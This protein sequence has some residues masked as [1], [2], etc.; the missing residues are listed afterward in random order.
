MRH[1]GLP[2]RAFVDVT[3]DEMAALFLFDTGA[4]ATHLTHPLGGPSVIA[5]AGTVR[6]GCKPLTLDSWPLVDMPKHDGLDLIGV[7][8]ADAVTMELVEL[9]L[10][11]DVLRVH[12]RVPDEVAGWP[13]VAI[14]LVHGVI[15]TRAT[16]DGRSMRMLLD[17]GTDTVVLLTENPGPGQVASTTDAAG[18][19]MKLVWGT[20]QLAWEG[21]DAR[22]VPA[23]RTR[24]H[25]MF[26]RHAQLLGGVDAI[27]GLA[28]LGNRRLLF[29]VA[30]G[31][32][33]V[34][35]L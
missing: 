31:R 35:P 7:L 3:K 24:A 30:H 16:V 26:E 20:A 17:T 18:A 14:E 13:V 22:R 33:H 6:L 5:R 29:D 8:G 2:V 9:D 34:E 27:L 10:R 4:A 32:V 12:R 25:P 19:P 11:A 1:E 28:P 15:L 23:W 21:T